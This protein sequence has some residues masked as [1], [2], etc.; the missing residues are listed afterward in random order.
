[1]ALITPQ[2]VRNDHTAIAK[3]YHDG[4][5]E[6]QLVKLAPADAIEQET[7]NYRKYIEG[8][9]GGRF[10]SQMVRD[11]IFWDLGGILYS[12]LDQAGPRMIT[13]HEYYD[14]TQNPLSILA[15]LRHFYLGTWRNFYD[16]SSPA[17][18]EEGL[19]DYYDRVFGLRKRMPGFL[20]QNELI[21]IPGIQELSLEPGTVAGEPYAG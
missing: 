1:M 4:R 13:F 14:K 16:R 2:S 18:R 20:D 5:F 6:P 21:M 17:S 8:N 3:V 15:P 19:G 10:N 7:A 9:L 12:F 11:V